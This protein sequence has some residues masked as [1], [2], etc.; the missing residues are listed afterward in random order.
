MLMASART[1]STV[2]VTAANLLTTSAPQKRIRPVSET[3]ISQEPW[4]E[5]PGIVVLDHC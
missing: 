5:N 3:A 4:M 1:D 2:P